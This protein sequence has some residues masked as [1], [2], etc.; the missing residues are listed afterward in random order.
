MSAHWQAGDDPAQVQ[1]ASA[2]AGAALVAEIYGAA[3][4]R[5]ETDQLV[6]R[7]FDADGRSAEGLACDALWLAVRK[8]DFI[9]AG[10]QVVWAVEVR[11]S[12]GGGSHLSGVGWLR[13]I[14]YLC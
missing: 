7:A 14:D 9:G 3:P 5:L 13:Y 1:G 2:L 6:K 8:W 11:L 4:A 12:V 10:T